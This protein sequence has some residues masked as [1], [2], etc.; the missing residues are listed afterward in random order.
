VV[1]REQGHRH[2]LPRR[3]SRSGYGFQV[4]CELAL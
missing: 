1:E 3:L 4:F 2:S